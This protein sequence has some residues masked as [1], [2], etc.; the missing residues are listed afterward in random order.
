MLDN[1]TEFKNRVFALIIISILIKISYFLTAYCFDKFN[2]LQLDLS[3]NINKFLSIFHKN[4][5]G[6]YQSITDNGYPIIKNKDELSGHLNGN[7]Y[8]SSWAFFPMFPAIVSVFKLIFNTDFD[9]AAFCITFF[10]STLTFILFYQTS[11]LYLKRKDQ[12][13]YCTLLFILYPFNYYYSMFYTESLFIC[14]MLGSFLAVYYK[15]HG[16]LFF[17]LAALTLTRPN[18]FV[19]C[20]VIYLYFVYRLKKEKNTPFLSLFFSRV[21]ILNSLVFLSVPITFFLYC[22]YQYNMTG[23]FFAFSTAQSGW[24]R[25][26]MFPLL[27]LFR[28]GDLQN[29]FHSIY[30][31]VVLLFTVVN[32]K[33]ISGYY[34]VLILTTIL[35][36]LSRG[37]MNGIPRYIS[38]LLPIYFIL[39]QYLEKFKFKN[40]ILILFYLLQLC[41]LYF[42]LGNA[43]FSY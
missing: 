43:P 5:A 32:Y 19:T 35:L 26:N 29:Q 2:L 7:L 28:K 21:F 1:K 13:W 3:W 40:T 20:F 23:D 15:K 6:W 42:W 16:L 38:I 31:C 22:L 24:D 36:P 10:F 14:F 33:K 8:Q 11:I 41:N 34:H 9:K 18:G 27:A 4:D 17:L 39:S 25:N 30:V 12:A 37:S